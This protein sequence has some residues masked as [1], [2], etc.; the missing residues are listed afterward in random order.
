MT[1][2]FAMISHSKQETIAIARVFGKALILLFIVLSKNVK[3]S[4]NF[5]QTTKHC[6]LYYVKGQFQSNDDFLSKVF[7]KWRLQ[8]YILENFL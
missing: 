1:A 2:I 8:N 6:N 7:S 3:N 5:S 4:R